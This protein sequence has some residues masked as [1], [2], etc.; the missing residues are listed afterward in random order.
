MQTLNISRIGDVLES[1]SLERFTANNTIIECME[2]IK[3]STNLL[4]PF[5]N[6]YLCLKE[7]W[8][9]VDDE[10]V[11]GYPD[12]M[13]IMV[14]ASTVGEDEYCREDMSEVFSSADMIP[15]LHEERDIP[16]VF[17]FSAVHFNSSWDMRSFREISQ[18]KNASI[19]YTETG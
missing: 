19:L 6:F 13:G 16:G 8:L 18:R 14:A 10:Q 12:K 15:K 7:N 2:N 3:N 9:D 17:Y 5:R 4:F 11:H 1:Y